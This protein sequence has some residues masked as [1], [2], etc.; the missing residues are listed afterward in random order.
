MCCDPKQLI[1]SVVGGVSAKS[2]VEGKYASLGFYITVHTK[3]AS[4]AMDAL[5]KAGIDYEHMKKTP[6]PGVQAF[7]FANKATRDKATG[8]LDKMHMLIG[9]K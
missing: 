6:V 4:K 7:A 8:I 9:T 2:I 3:N 5:K 1:E